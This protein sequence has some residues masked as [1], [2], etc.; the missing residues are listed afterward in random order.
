MIII[1]Y[2][3]VHPDNVHSVLMLF[4][5]IKRKMDRT[6]GMILFSILVTYLAVM[7]V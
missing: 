1:R 7:I 3:A 4:M 6:S 5:F 2:L